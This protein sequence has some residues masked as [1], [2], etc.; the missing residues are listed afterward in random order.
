MDF[1]FGLQNFESKRFI[2]QMMT[3]IN[4]ELEDI[5]DSSAIAS[6]MEIYNKKL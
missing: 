2:S 6:F 1:Q 5:R 3:Q 4:R